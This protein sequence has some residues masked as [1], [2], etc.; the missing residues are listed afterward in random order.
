MGIAIALC[1]FGA[2]CGGVIH[3]KAGSA[4]AAFAAAFVCWLAAP[5]L[6]PF[7]THSSAGRRIAANLDTAGAGETPLLMLLAAAA[8]GVLV[9]WVLFRGREH[10]PDW[11]WDPDHP[12][13]RKR[14]RRRYA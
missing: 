4:A 9:S 12:K 13:A 11:E 1:L 14:R 2:I 8:L 10:R 7:L 3:N 5:A 6:E